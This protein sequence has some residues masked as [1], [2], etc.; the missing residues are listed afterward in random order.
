MSAHDIVVVADLRFTGGTSAALAAD[1]RAFAAL[2][3]TVGILPV[4]SAFLDAEDAVESPA[5]SALFDLPAVEMAH[6]PVRCDL[7]FL[8]NPLIF[9]EP[10]EGATPITARRTVV[11]AHHPPFR[12][13]GSLEYNPVLVSARVRMA[14]GAGPL[15]TGAVWAP[16]SGV[17]RR[18]LRAFTPLISMTRGDWANAFDP[19][20]WIATR[21][22]FAPAATGRPVAT[23]GRHGRADVLKWPD[24]AADM[25]APLSPGP[26]WRASVMGCPPEVLRMAGAAAAGWEVLAFGARPVA[27]FLDRLDVF[28]FHFHP[29]WVEAFGRTVAE[30]ILMERPCILDPRLAPTFADLA[31]YASPAEAPD[32]ARR[33]RAA[34]EA[35]RATAAARRPR[36]IS[37]FGNAAI[38]RRVAE[39]MRDGGTRS[40]AGPKAAPV[41]VTLRKAIGLSRRRLAGGR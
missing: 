39:L 40:R 27:D 6:G 1:V 28:V 26:G 7:A 30:A 31:D 35:A 13:D 10:F 18:Q 9:A 24:A 12:G 36:A 11:V 25:V 32:L 41:A 38:G 17:I 16:V 3:M 37:A 33:L 22:A 5:I 2:G 23:I 19:G 15:G 20:D 8:H 29:R 21:P 14:F 34:P 4:R